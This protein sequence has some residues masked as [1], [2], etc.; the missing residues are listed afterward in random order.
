MLVIFN[1]KTGSLWGPQIFKCHGVFPCKEHW[2]F[3]LNLVRSRIKLLF[4]SSKPG[5]GSSRTL[6]EPD[7]C[8]T[9]NHGWSSAWYHLKWHTSLQGVRFQHWKRRREKK[10]QKKGHESVLWKKNNLWGAQA[11]LSLSLP[12]PPI[13]LRAKQRHTERQ[14]RSRFEQ[15]EAT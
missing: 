2:G 10:K 15:E 12:V 13:F 5:P 9:R 4:P 11:G 3:W 14:I 7:R 1:W 6:K 8:K